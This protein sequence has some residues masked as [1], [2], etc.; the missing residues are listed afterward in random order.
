MADTQARLQAIVRGR[1][2]GVGFRE[3]VWRRASILGVTGYVRNLPD[4]RSVEVVAEGERQALEQLLA[5]LREGPPLSV[6]NGV[7]VEWLAASGRFS[8]FEVAL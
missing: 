1:V 3:F 7:D 4:G 2:Q 5:Y 6:V 8:S